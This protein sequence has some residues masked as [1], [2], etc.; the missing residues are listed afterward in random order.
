MNLYKA[1]LTKLGIKADKNQKLKAL[2]RAMINSM[3]VLKAKEALD[4]F[5]ESERIKFDLE[6]DLRFPDEFSNHVIV[7]LWE[8]IPLENEFRAFVFDHKLTAIS[9]YFTQIYFPQL[10][11]HKT[12]MLQQIKQFWLS[13]KDAFEY[14]KFVIDFAIKRDGN[15][16]V[17]ELNPYNI[18]TGSSLFSW[19][20]EEDSDIMEGLKPFEFRI[21]ESPI[22]ETL[23]NKLHPVWKQLLFSDK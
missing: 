12:E 21:L 15:A 2:Y 17:L 13:C 11:E 3:K 18:S 19:H 5:V 10:V 14:E 6:L 1:A 8:D 23:K 9:Q 16:V 22:V 7:R 4:M 20:S